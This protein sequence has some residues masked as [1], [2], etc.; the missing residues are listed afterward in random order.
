M[1]QSEPFLIIEVSHFG[2]ILNEKLANKN[3]N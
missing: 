1:K 3:L 2:Y